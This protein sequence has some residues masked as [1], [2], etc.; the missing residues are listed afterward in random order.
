MIGDG[1]LVDLADAAFLGAH[2]TGEVTEVIECERNVGV[3]GFTDRF[4]VVH[5]FDVGQPFEVGLH[6]VGDL[7][8]HIG[9]LAGRSLS[10][11]VGGR[12]GG[13]QR[14]L[15]VFG[16]GAGGLGEDGTVDR[17]DHIEVFT[18]DRR[19]PLAADKVVVLGFEMDQ[20]F[21]AS[22]CGIDHVVSFVWG[23]VRLDRCCNQKPLRK[24]HA[25]VASAAGSLVEMR[26]SGLPRG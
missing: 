8:Q 1:V 18:L 7:E 13:V 6:A 22:G 2:A 14:Q 19:D 12:V 26:K 11:S 4:A 16:T 21:G 3:Q 10:P 5:G 23:V 15:D 9:T 20:G 25:I 17:G 24:D